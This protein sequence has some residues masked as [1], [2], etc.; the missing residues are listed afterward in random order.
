MKTIK[1]LLSAIFLIAASFA[2]A[3]DSVKIPASSDN[4]NTYA[5]STRMP[6]VRAVEKALAKVPGKAAWVGMEN[7]GGSLATLVQV[8]REDHS[9]KMVWFESGRGTITRVEDFTPK[10]KKG[11]KE[12]PKQEKPDGNC[13]LK[14]GSAR[15][16]DWPYV[17]KVSLVQAMTAAMTAHRGKYV[18]AY[19]F[20]KGGCL[21]VGVE[22][23][24]KN[25]RT[26]KYD[27]DAATGALVKS[28]DMEGGNG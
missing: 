20:E 4:E 7:V 25:L 11:D 12:A 22:I 2:S 14:V 16:E 5:H 27:V 24:A 23:S 3:A 21:F 6:L 17:S 13:G 18:E 10:P 8:V 15:E 26:T 28:E 9:Q 1:A 19:F